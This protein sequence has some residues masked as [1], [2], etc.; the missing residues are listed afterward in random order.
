M[1]VGEPARLLRCPARR[2][3][4][5]IGEVQRQDDVLRHAFRAHLAEEREARAF[6]V[7][8]PVADLTGLA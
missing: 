7:V 6:G 8:K 2:V 4:R 1:V 3:Q 5:T